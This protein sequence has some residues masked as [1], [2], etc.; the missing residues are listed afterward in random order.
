MVELD[1]LFESLRAAFVVY[2]PDTLA[3]MLAVNAPAVVK[4]E[5]LPVVNA[6]LSKLRQESPELLADWAAGRAGWF[7]R[8]DDAF[9]LVPAF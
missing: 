3:D 4:P 6:G 5:R 7:C 8:G 2:T 1:C 9:E